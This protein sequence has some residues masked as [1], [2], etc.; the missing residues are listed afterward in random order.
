MASDLSEAKTKL[1]KELRKEQ[2]HLENQNKL[3]NEL[4]SLKN[5]GNKAKDSYEKKIKQLQADLK[6]AENEKSTEIGKLRGK[7]SSHKM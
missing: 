5:E 6:K 1:E 7:L 3:E 2:L 4:Q